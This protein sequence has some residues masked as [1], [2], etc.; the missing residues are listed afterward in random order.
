MPALQV[1]RS[2]P[3]ARPEGFDGASKLLAVPFHGLALPEL[4]KTK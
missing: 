1:C 2:T 3:L 4:Y